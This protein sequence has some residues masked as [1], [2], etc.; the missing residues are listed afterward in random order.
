MS[1]TEYLPTSAMTAT[2]WSLAL[3]SKILGFDIMEVWSGDEKGK[4][5]CSYVHAEERVKE[6]YPNII[7]GHYPQHKQDHKLSPKVSMLLLDRWILIDC[8]TSYLNTMFFGFL[9][10]VTSYVNWLRNVQSI[11]IGLLL[12]E[13]LIVILT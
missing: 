4:L 8:F 11:V 5:F 2:S 9:F 3:A 10:S 12:I 6:L 1:R 13:Q 7:T